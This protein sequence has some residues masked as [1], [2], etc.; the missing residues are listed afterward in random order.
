MIAVENPV[1]FFDI[2]IG[3]MAKGRIEIELRADVVPKTSENFRYRYK[4]LY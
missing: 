4:I 2:A 1:V 3:G